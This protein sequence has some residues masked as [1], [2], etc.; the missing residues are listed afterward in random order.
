MP[1]HRAA[2]HVNHD[3]GCTGA[4]GCCCCCSNIDD[5]VTDEL[6]SRLLAEDSETA[7]L[8]V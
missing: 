5:K 7:E 1:D 6:K 4:A 3:V 8:T 2:V